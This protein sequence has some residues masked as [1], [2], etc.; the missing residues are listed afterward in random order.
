MNS[1]PLRVQSSNGD[2]TLG[3]AF[4]HAGSAFHEE[5]ALAAGRLRAGERLYST[6]AQGQRAHRARRAV[7]LQDSNAFVRVKSPHAQPVRLG[8]R[9][10]LN[11]EIT[12]GLK[13][14]D[15]VVYQVTLNSIPDLS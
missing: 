4:T 11:V 15:V 2:Q 6:G 10:G 13:E 3:H 12:D 8:T 14:G 7:E 9:D 1:C 5:S